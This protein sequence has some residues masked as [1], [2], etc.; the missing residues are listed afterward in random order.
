MTRDSSAYCRTIA[1]RPSRETRVG[2]SPSGEP[3][4]RRGH[5][6]RVARSAP[7]ATWAD[8]SDLPMLLDLYDRAQSQ[9]PAR[10]LRRR[11]S[12][13]LAGCRIGGAPA[14]SQFLARF[15]APA[16]RR[17]F[18]AT[19]IVRSAPRGSRG[20]AAEQFRRVVRST[21]TGRSSS[22]GSCRRTTGSPIPT[23][24][25]ETPRGP[26]ELELYPGDAPLAVDYFVQTIESGTVV[27]TEFTRVVAGF[28]RPAADDSERPRAF[29]TR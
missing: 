11:L 3:T 29:A 12:R 21:N 15:S 8:T 6:H 27:G 28:R 24:R 9:A 4:F 22:G 5:D 18:G 10:R 2:R 23:A 17:F 14:R 26:I 7:M 1:G 20:V 25:W 13:R 19:S 16:E